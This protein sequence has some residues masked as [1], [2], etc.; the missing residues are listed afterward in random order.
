VTG[1]GGVL[2]GERARATGGGGGAGLCESSGRERV[3]GIFCS[4]NAG[5]SGAG[6]LRIA[7]GISKMLCRM[8]SASFTTEP[9]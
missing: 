7:G 9:G 4:V 2:I 5:V 6:G 8:N 3:G 1:G